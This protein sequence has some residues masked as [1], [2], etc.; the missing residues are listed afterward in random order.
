MPLAKGHSREI[1]SSNIKEMVKSGRPAKQAIA[2]SL[3]MA[4][5]SKKMAMGGMVDDEDDGT[6]MMA[7][8][9]VYPKGD[10]SQGLS[11]QVMD[12]QEENEGLQAEKYSANDN[13]NS[14]EADDMVAGSKMAKGGLAQSELAQALGNK[15]DLDWIND[16]TGEPM[17]SMPDKPASLGHE[18][19]SGVPGGMGL[20]K[21][22]MEALAMKKK[23][24]RFQQ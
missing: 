8:D 17:G 2:A 1:I 21:E 9:P 10:D 12:A 3:A 11:E 22:A 14:Y 18:M 15:P 13:T 7:G 23:N 4:R 5:K 24:R 6:S 20:S 16:G 19:I